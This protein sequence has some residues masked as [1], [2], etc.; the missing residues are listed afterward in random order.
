MSNIKGFST[1][2]AI[3]SLTIPGGSTLQ[4]II[5]PEHKNISIPIE[6]RLYVHYAGPDPFDPSFESAGISNSTGNDV[7]ITGD[8]ITPIDTQK[9]SSVTGISISNIKDDSFY[10]S[11]N[12]STDNMIVTGYNVYLNGSKLNSSLLQTTNLN[13]TSLTAGTICNITVTAVDYV[14]NESNPSVIQTIT[15]RQPTA[16]L[17]TNTVRGAAPLTIQAN[18][19]SSTDPDGSTGDFVLGY[20]FNFGDGSPIENANSVSHTYS[21]QGVYTLSLV[22]VDTRDFRSTA[23]TQIINVIADIT[24][25]SVPTNLIVSNVTTT[26]LNISWSPST[27]NVSVSGYAISVN[28]VSVVAS[29]TGTSYNV[30]GLTAG[31]NYT[32][33]I[34]AIDGSGNR[35]SVASLSTTTSQA[36]DVTPPSIP[37]NLTVSNVTTTS[38]NLSWTASTDNVSV[39]GYSI[40][41]NGVSVVASQ[42]GTSYNV[43]GLTAATDYTISI[44][45][46]D[47]VG[48]RS[49]IAEV[50]TT[51]ANIL[52]LKSISNSKSDIYIYPNPAFGDEVNFSEVATGVVY[53]LLGNAIL[54]F[55]NVKV[56]AIS[57]FIKGIYFVKFNS[58]KTIKW[59]CSYIN[60]I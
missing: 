32:I 8:V 57:E 28:G 23:V 37:T 20:D 19:L 58:G 46:I 43:T 35:S 45:A 18:G 51:T 9:P 52:S 1:T 33:S 11:W 60:N 14:G 3:A 24:S 47:A 25:P 30:T 50:T 29:Q 16:I 26:S 44:V 17:V 10:L 40:S 49:L 53:D 15:N 31:T 12:E 41:V 42:T 34:Q 54:S 2:N 27:D 21:T 4:N 55:K 5:I 13:V 56:L 7:I 36:L 48:N 59:L 6:F 38:F 39:S 22:V